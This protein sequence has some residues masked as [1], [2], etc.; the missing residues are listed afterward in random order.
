[1][2]KMKTWKIAIPL[3]LARPY[4]LLLSNANFI[5]V[6]NWWPLLKTPLYHS[7][8]LQ[9]IPGHHIQEK[10]HWSLDHHLKD[11]L[12]KVWADPKRGKPTQKIV[13]EC[14][15]RKRR[16]N[17]P[18][19]KV[20]KMTRMRNTFTAL[21]YIPKTRGER[22]GVRQMSE[23]VTQKLCRCTWLEDLNLWNL[24]QWL[25]FCAF[26]QMGSNVGWY[27]KRSATTIWC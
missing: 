19:M 12:R 10:Q 3:H 22:S 6:E 20:A 16:R 26:K 13:K 4:Q 2:E 7:P 23:V 18:M 27:P 14:C 5:H 1:M 25:S 11:N 9:I 15:K 21:V 24:F 8:C 17:Y